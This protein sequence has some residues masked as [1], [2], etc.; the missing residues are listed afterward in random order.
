[1]KKLVRDQQDEEFTLV[2]LVPDGHGIIVD[3]KKSYNISDSQRKCN[4][5]T[6][7]FIA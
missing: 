1:M 5:L 3:L 2:G 7:N 6:L 4:G